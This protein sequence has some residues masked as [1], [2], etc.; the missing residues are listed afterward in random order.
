MTTA[1]FDTHSFVKRLMAAGMPEPQAE[2][3]AEEQSRLIGDGTA[4]KA[5]VSEVRSDIAVV[6]A[7]LAMIK[8]MVGGIGF[9][10][11]ALIIKSFMPGG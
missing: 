3:L 4:T 11:L 7:E 2:I 9:G 10:V 8:W 6:R 5:D 1:I